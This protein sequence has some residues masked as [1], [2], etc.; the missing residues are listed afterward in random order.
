MSEN[1]N[2]R[3]KN[4][5]KIYYTYALAAIAVIAVIS[6]TLIL[7]TTNGIQISQA[8][9]A[10][11][12]SSQSTLPAAYN[13]NNNN[14]MGSSNDN[15]STAT[16]NNT[17]TAQTM[18]SPQLTGKLS[19]YILLLDYGVRYQSSEIVSRMDSSLLP[20]ITAAYY[21]TSGDSPKGAY[22]FENISLTEQNI[23]A[24]LKAERFK[25]GDT[26]R[27]AVFQPQDTV[28]I[29]IGVDPVP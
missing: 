14:A 7:G 19:L 21:T 25:A 26:V 10:L 12:S 18:S 2:K 5:K 13:N 22:T 9:A 1:S 8:T 23:T 16:N 20:K 3:S 29:H 24:D 11:G 15:A 17:T 6:G 27:M 28:K 4:N